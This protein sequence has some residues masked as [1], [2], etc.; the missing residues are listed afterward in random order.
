MAN[1]SVGTACISNDDE[2]VPPGLRSPY[3]E[4]QTERFRARLGER[5]RF[6]AAAGRFR[7]LGI[8]FWLAVTLLE[9]GE[10]EGVEE[11]RA[12][13]EQLG[14]APWLARIDAGAVARAAL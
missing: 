7:E 5:E 3:L 1:W 13:F 2:S 11:A 12:I 14:A 4:G 9:Q 6:A 8:P 10:T